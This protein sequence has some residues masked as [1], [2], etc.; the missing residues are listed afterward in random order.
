VEFD[1]PYKITSE[2]T[3][4][5]KEEDIFE[6]DVVAMRKNININELAYTQSSYFMLGEINSFT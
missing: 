1:I 2:M 6:F 3:E 4:E 5:I